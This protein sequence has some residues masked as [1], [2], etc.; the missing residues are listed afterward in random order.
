MPAV[1]GRRAS[2]PEE[3]GIDELGVDPA[4]L[5]RLCGVGDLHQLARRGVGI[6]KRAVAVSLNAKAEPIV[7]DLVKPFDGVACNLR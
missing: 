4:V 7:L 6:G 2:S 3:D 1:F 5:H